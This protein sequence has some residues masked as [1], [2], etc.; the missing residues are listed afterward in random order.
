MAEATL[1]NLVYFIRAQ[2]QQF[3]QVVNETDSYLKGIGATFN[4]GSKQ[5]KDYGVSVTKGL[6]DARKSIQQHKEAIQSMAIGS[7][8]ALATMVMQIRRSI[9]ETIDM[10]NSLAGLSSVAKAFHHDVGAVNQAAKDLSADG[11]MTLADAA[12][13]LKNLMMSGFGL[14]ESI[15]L[16]ERFKDI[17]AF[18]RQGSLGFGQAIRGATEGIKNQNSMLVDNIG[19]T[20][21]LS[22][23]LKEAGYSETD[24]MRVTTDA[25]VR[26]ALY[27]GLLK[28]ASYF[29]GDAAKMAKLLSGQMAQT[30]VNVQKL[31]RALEST[32]DKPLTEFLETV[33]DI[34][35]KTTE[36]ISRNKELVGTL[37]LIT[38]GATGATLAISASVL[39]IDK[40]IG[41][42]KTAITIVKNSN[43]LFAL[44]WIASGAG[45]A[46]KIK[47]AGE[48]I[49]FLAASLK[50]LL[51]A[52]AVVAYFGILITLISKLISEQKRMEE[53][54]RNLADT[55]ANQ[56]KA[57]ENKARNLNKLIN[58]YEELNKIEKRSKE[59]QENLNNVIKEIGRIVPNAVT[60]WDNLGNAISIN[61]AKAKDAV[62]EMLGVRKALLN[63]SIQR[64]EMER[65]LLEKT[66][67]DN[68]AAVK[69]AMEDSIVAEERFKKAQAKWLEIQQIDNQIIGLDGKRDPLWEHQ[70]RF[71][72]N[73]YLKA[74]KDLL[75]AKEREKKVSQ[76][77]LDAQE[78]LLNLDA[79]IAERK[80]LIAAE[81]DIFKEEPATKSGGGDDGRTPYQAAKDKFEIYARENQA[82]E[83]QLKYWKEVVGAVK[84]TDKEKDDYLKKQKELENELTDATKKAQDELAQARE[85]GYRRELL[86]LNQ[87]EEE[88]LKSVAA[89][90]ERE[91]LIRERYRIERE[92]LTKKWD[93]ETKAQKWELEAALLEI[94][95][96]FENA[97]IL[98]EKARF[99]REYDTTKLSYDQLETLEKEHQQK[100]LE[101]TNEYAGKRAEAALALEEAKI[102]SQ[103]S[104]LEGQKKILSLH[105]NQ[106]MA[107][108]EI[109]RIEQQIIDLQIQKINALI[110]VKEQQLEIA[111]S[112]HDQYET[113]KLIAELKG[114]KTERDELKRERDYNEKR[115]IADLSNDLKSNFSSAVETGL[116]DGGRKGVDSLVDYLRQ[117]AKERIADIITEAFFNSQTGK[118]MESW[119]TSA[120]GGSD[121]GGLFGFLG[122]LFG[123][124]SKSPSSQIPDNVPIDRSKLPQQGGGFLGGLGKIFNSALSFLGPFALLGSLFG[125]LFG[126]GSK[127]FTIQ[128]S[129]ANMEIDFATA[130]FKE[131]TLPSS[132]MGRGVPGSNVVAPVQN[133]YVNVNAAGSLLAERDLN[134]RIESGVQAGIAKANAKSKKWQSVTTREG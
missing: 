9:K 120:F 103:I 71:Y 26:Q 105:W 55:T 18:N 3:K 119:F 52:G 65:P 7:A 121:Q 32:I 106:T 36:W 113:E 8:A 29:T 46:G 116:T 1:G 88:E 12:T 14:Q 130:N 68:E 11:L 79:D 122:G 2:N 54:E 128:A 73:A 101:I 37:T 83:D 100:L 127:S 21:N 115:Y 125:D 129:T 82:L 44:Q 72:R 4:K 6:D 74:E 133:I 38:T 23:I 89:G 51:I 93:A 117:K 97:D 78:K 34:L 76:K 104:E 64:A 16:M 41:I 92:N 134:K 48:A 57:Y 84:K 132:Y 28:E 80:A 17:A 67:K 60:Q 96:D 62:K 111:E 69:K 94:K 15:N 110:A 33:N 99:A 86:A 107:K 24:L 114:L 118:I 13:G 31:Y 39:A 102:D 77:S 10:Q 25:G 35:I 40:L 30:S 45:F 87:K 109:L 112:I 108:R 5:A 22:I 98:R 47:A 95:G 61:T 81:G 124:G 20:K 49:G 90:S 126:G 42:I 63:I 58:Q 123:G 131:V 43:L 85:R 50:G 59:E 66:I 19:L 70:Y 75:K 27:N 56:A 53:A 91:K